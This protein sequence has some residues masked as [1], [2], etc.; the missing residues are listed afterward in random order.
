MTDKPPSQNDRSDETRD[1]LIN[2][3]L[4]NAVLDIAVCA[5]LATLEVYRQSALPASYLGGTDQP[6]DHDL[7][8]D[9][10]PVTQADL[11]SHQIISQSLAQLTPST[12]VVSEEDEVSLKYRQTEG[13]F[14]LID[15]LDGTKEFIARQGDFTVNIALIVNGHSVLGVVFAPALDLL[16]SGGSGR[17]G[18]SGVGFGAGYGTGLG[19]DFNAWCAEGRAQKA[20]SGNESVGLVKASPISVSMPIVGKGLARCRVVAS[21]SHM[22][23]ATTDFITALGEVDL[24]QAGSSLKICRIAQGLADVYPRLAPT[25]EWDTAAAQA[26]L[27]G[28]GGHMYDLQGRRLQ[29]GKPDV[30]NPSFVAANMAFSE[31]PEPCRSFHKG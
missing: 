25:C 12:P 2:D 28:A 13:A 7:K 22:N 4:V 23:Q 21:K 30:L 18:G 3:S 17:G 31:L 24:V 6:I 16:F 15:P 9:K 26:V 11:A 5:G 8:A 19:A 29:Y 10:S 1:E 20:L 27:E 14:W